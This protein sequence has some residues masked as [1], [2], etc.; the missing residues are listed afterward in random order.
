M[1]F[2]AH[3]GETDSAS[4]ALRQLMERYGGA[5]HRY[6]LSVTRDPELA[7][8]LAQ[9]FALRFLRGAFRRADPSR[10]RF[11][12][13]VKTAA[14]NLMIDAY[15]RTRARPLPLSSEIPEPVIPGLDLADLDR[16]FYECWREELLS[17]AWTRLAQLQDESGT[18]YYAVL[19]FRVDHADLRSAEMA[20]HLTVRL[21]KRVSASWVRQ[22]LHRAREKFVELLIREVAHS[23]GNPTHE[24]LDDE[25]R[26]MDLWSYCRHSAVSRRPDAGRRMS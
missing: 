15:R 10:G 26:N 13:F 3:E 25:L 19:R 9:E 14:M 22:T 4:V 16:R 8:D 6:L 18:P 17:H 24:E 7:A 12:D 21:G 2:R 1:V 23:L 11:R 20:E 5:V